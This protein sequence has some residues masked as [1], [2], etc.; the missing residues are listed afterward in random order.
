MSRIA[1]L[2]CALTLVMV[3]ALTATPAVAAPRAVHDELAG[4][5]AA[6]YGPLIDC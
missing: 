2:L 6:W 3:V 1:R 5:A 4:V